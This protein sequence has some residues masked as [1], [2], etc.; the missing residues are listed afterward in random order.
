MKNRLIWIM[1]GVVF[2]SACGLLATPPPTP[3]VVVV[4]VVTNTP[5]QPATPTAVPATMTAVPAT[6]TAV[7]ATRTSRPAPKPSMTAQPTK[8]ATVSPQVLVSCQKEVA[9]FKLRVLAVRKAYRPLVDD[10]YNYSIELLAND[11]DEADVDS[12][13]AGIDTI[14]V[15]RCVDA[16]EILY[17]FRLLRDTLW[18]A[19]IEMRI[20]SALQYPSQDSFAL[21]A[22]WYQEIEG[23]E[24]DINALI[25]TL[26]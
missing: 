10:V 17:Y 6:V 1:L 5:P 13:F 21:V 25:A 16:G 4:V 18:P 24:R 8:A 14:E 2:M 15:P 26:P 9:A 19:H 7:P 20:E 3:I 22:G 23:F 11:Y 12:A